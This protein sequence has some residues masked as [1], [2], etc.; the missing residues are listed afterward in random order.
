MKVA[1]LSPSF[2][3]RLEVAKDSAEP[4]EISGSELAV[5]LS[6]FVWSATPDEALFA[7]AENGSLR[8]EKEV[9]Y[10]SE[11][12]PNSPKRLALAENFAGQW[13]GFDELKR[14]KV[15]YRGE[16]W[17][18]GVYDELL[19]G[20]DELIKSDRSILEIVDSDWAYIRREHVKQ[21]GAKGHQFE[22]KFADIFAARRS[23]AGLK[24][25][26]FYDPPRLYK[27][28]GG[29][30]GGMLTAA[31]IMRLTSAPNRTSPI[32]RGVWLLEKIIGEEMQPPANI[33]PLAEA[34]KRI[35]SKICIQ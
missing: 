23:R 5:R 8:Q 14:N 28:T 29:R 6:Y 12:M 9:R 2:M 16:N 21:T 15:F 33:P 32:R 17:T 10:Q 34:K 11:R 27:F 31:G 1:L 3:E 13:L 26:R 30:A 19:F 35:P 22:E 4:Y 24:V 7:A 25:E 20:F 18:R